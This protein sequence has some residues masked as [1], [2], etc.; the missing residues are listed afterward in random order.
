[1]LTKG[2]DLPLLQKPLS[3]HFSFT[4][5]NATRIEEMVKDF[6]QC[7][8]ELKGRVSSGQESSS[9][10]LYGACAKIPDGFTK[11]EIMSEI[12]DTYIDV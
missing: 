10:Q 3:I 7:M 5:L 12:L 2:W 9:V 11:N 6:K 8:S 4:P 1:M